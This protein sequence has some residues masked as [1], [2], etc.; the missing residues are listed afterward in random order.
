LTDPI[1]I[2]R[3]VS[4]LEAAVLR[5]WLTA[6]GETARR[7]FSE[8][9]AA[10]DANGLTMLVYS[11][12]VIAA[13]RKFG[14]QYTRADLIGYV[15]GIR[16]KLQSDEPGLLDPLTAED[17]LRAA[18][19]EPVTGTHELGFVAAARIFILIDLVTSLDLPE[20]ALT[21][22]LAQARH[23]ADQMIEHVS[24]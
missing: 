18:L 4:D 2:P 10:G 9:L 1:W 22:L 23:N 3:P 19:G 20:E 15:A 7:A 5:G 11:A 16:A 13:R 14:R 6:D 24:L 8:Q 12:F 21:D 17:E